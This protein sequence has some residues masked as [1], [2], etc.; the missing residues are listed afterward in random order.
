MLIM[1]RYVW[2]MAG[3]LFIFAIWHIKLSAQ[4]TFKAMITDSITQ[5]NL[6]SVVIVVKGTT[7]SAGTDSAGN[8][9]ITN[10]PNGNQVIDVSYIG[11]QKQSIPVQFPQMNGKVFTIK[12]Q[13]DQSE[14]GE[15]LVTS[16]RTNSRVEDAP[17]KIEVLG[18]EDLH[19]ESS[20]KPGNVASLIGDVSGIQI[21][22]TSA[23]S[24]NSVVRMQGLDGRYTLLL[25]DG[26]P[27]YGGLSTGLSILQIPP[28]DLKQVEII[29]GPA[30]TI[31]GGGAISGLI[32]FITKEPTDTPEATFLLNQSSLLE[33]NFNAYLSGKKD[34]IGYTLFAGGNHQSA[35]DVNGDGFSD[36]P[37]TFS[38]VVHPQLFF[39]PDANTHI[40]V[41]FIGNY[42]NREGGDMH[43]IHGQ[44]DSLHQYFETNVSQNYGMDVIVNHDLKNKQ[45]IYFRASGNYFDRSLTTN[46]AEQAG[47]QGT[48]YS[49]LYYQIPKGRHNFIVGGNYLLDIFHRSP[50]DTS[51]YRNYS[52]HTG[53]VF[54]QYSYNVENKLNLQIGLRGDY[55]NVYG[56][57]I[58]PS[59]AILVH[60][61]RA[62]SIR[63]NG[64]TG[65]K[66]PNIV[67]IMGLE[68]GI[69]IIPLT[70]N[71][72]PEHSYGGTAE[73]NY[74]KLFDRHGLSL[75]I[76][77][78]FFYTWV[79]HAIISTQDTSGNYT[80]ANVNNGATTM[81][82]DN[83]VRI[84][85]GPLE[86]YLGYTFVYPRK[87][88]DK[89][90]PF[91]TLTPLHRGATV[92]SYDINRHWKVG[93]EGSLVGKQYLDVG[94]PTKPYFLF[95]SSIHY[96]VKKV[97]LVLNGENLLNVRQSHYAPVVYAPYTRPRFAEIWAP[98][99]GIV[100]N[101]SILVKI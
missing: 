36:V 97:T 54:A 28:L 70:T 78:T 53:G 40:R 38:V 98:V 7:N 91:L 100:I 10:I 17:I 94:S 34:K 68:E 30:S 9:E 3:L 62:F 59:A 11:Y 13:P 25:R 14:L 84:K 77:Q 42:E 61:S 49:E 50:G 23:L 69:N 27:S 2:K 71:L 96:T 32:N 4:N 47:Y 45:G 86:I 16:N 76:N 90:Q 44:V 21:Q 33:T 18:A 74:R 75:F 51:S 19:E 82:V 39:Y 20:I 81:G 72:S 63:V 46:Y 26:M 83:Y 99:D 88:F 87:E 37:K 64:G 65:Y 93:V 66:V 43:V 41:G 8:A 80:I 79:Q 35:L 58:L 85:K 101:F 22:Q 52:Y 56:F 31:N 15:V 55:Q 67:E 1:K 24:G 6:N 12:L 29:K 73:W 92:V 48:G 95:S 89:A 60:A 57:F 5:E